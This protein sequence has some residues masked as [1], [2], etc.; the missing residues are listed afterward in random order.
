MG[1]AVRLKSIIQLD[2][3]KLAVS[4]PDMYWGESF[5]V[6]STNTREDKKAIYASA[7]EMKCRIIVKVSIEN[8]IR[9]LRVW[10]IEPVLY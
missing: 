7:S 2:G 6:P 3:W 5:F 1:P 8:E 4:W 10:I 9:G